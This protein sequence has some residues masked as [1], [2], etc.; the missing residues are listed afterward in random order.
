MEVKKIW[1]IIHNLLRR[2]DAIRD[3]RC[4][5]STYVTYIVTLRVGHC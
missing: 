4:Y 5:H 2:G 1:T 3:D